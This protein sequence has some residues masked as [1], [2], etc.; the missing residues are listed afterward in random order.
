MPRRALRD[1]VRNKLAGD[2][3]QCQPNMLVSDRVKQFCRSRGPPDTGQVIGQHRPRADPARALKIAGMAES[4][5]RLPQAPGLARVSRRIGRGE[6]HV[7]RG[8]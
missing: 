3:S 4:A 7:T 2:G 8:A 1:E 6:F 5:Q